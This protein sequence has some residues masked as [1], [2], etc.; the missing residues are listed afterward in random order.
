MREN[1]HI[2]YLGT[3]GSGKTTLMNRHI[4][5]EA[6][7][8]FSGDRGESS[9][10]AV[11]YPH[12][13]AAE[14]L[15]LHLEDRGHLWR[16]IVRD[17]RNLKT[18]LPSTIL[19]VSSKADYWERQ[20][21][22][23]LYRDIFLD[24]VWRRRGTEQRM[25]EFTTIEKAAKIICSVYQTL[26]EW[27]APSLMWLMLEKNHPVQ[28]WAR[29]HCQDPEALA[30]FEGLIGM[31]NHDHMAQVLPTQRMFFNFYESSPIKAMCSTYPTID[32]PLW[33]R[34]R[35]IYVCIGGGGRDAI[36]SLMGAEI[37]QISADVLQTP[38]DDPIYLYIDEA[39]NYDLV[40]R[41]EAENAATMRHH[42][43]F[44]RFGLQQY[45]QD[46][47]I[48]TPLRQNLN[49][50]YIF[51]QND[52][53]MSD[54][55]SRDLVATTD[56][57]RVHH[58]EQRRKQEHDGFIEQERQSI[59]TGKGKEDSWSSVARSTAPVAQYR[60]VLE[61]T[62][63]YEDPNHQIFWQSRDLRIQPDMHYF[64][65]FKNEMPTR[66]VVRWLPDL[67]AFKEDY[68]AE[69]KRCLQRAM[70]R[71]DIYRSPEQARLPKVE[72]PKGMR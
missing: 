11:F 32:V 6:D 50:K 20:A 72:G 30:Q 54:E 42:N 33:L 66:H 65:L 31:N 10:I 49:C 45:G 15:L 36:K 48:W 5:E 1:V 61:E 26:D 47:S 19:R 59:T 70:S 12:A 23:Q 21:E 2:A 71:T 64:R 55:A 67:C 63:R 4:L 69:V 7:R 18:I 56:R 25:T 17:M 27:L 60:D 14:R 53:E 8:G 13:D 62:P 43:G 39:V 68:S 28:S 52:P 46:K 9:G 24:L 34:H 38:C 37:Q 29:N 44:L 57:M 22:N 3:S 16:T 41:L 40:S 58:V 35:F 51:R